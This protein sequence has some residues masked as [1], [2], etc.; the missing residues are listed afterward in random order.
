M[1]NLTKREL[2]A[3]GILTIVAVAASLLGSLSREIAPVVVSSTAPG[4]LSE[5]TL[6]LTAA[7]LN[8]LGTD[9]SSIANDRRIAMQALI[10][11][12]PQA[13]VDA[14]LSDQDLDRL[15][16]ALW[17]YL[18]VPATIEGQF[19]AGFR[20]YDDRGEEFFEIT[21][22]DTTYTVIPN[23]AALN[24]DV[25]GRVRLSGILIDDTLV[26]DPALP[27]FPPSGR[28]T[29]HS[30][31]S[32]EVLAGSSADTTPPTI[33]SITEVDQSDSSGI[34]YRISWTTNEAVTTQLTYGTNRKRLN[35]IISDNTLTTTHN[36]LL[37]NLPAGSWIY[38][39]ITATDGSGNTAVTGLLRF[40]TSGGTTSGGSTGGGGGG[41]TNNIPVAKDDS[42]T[43]AHTKSVSFNVLSNDT[44]KD[45]KDTLSLATINGAVRQNNLTL[46]SGAT[47]TTT[48]TG[49]I[50][51][52][53]NAA[54][55]IETDTFS[56]TAT[57]GKDP[58]NP[59]TVTITITG[60]TAQND[61]PIANNDSSTTN[62]DTAVTINVRANDTDPNG[63]ALTIT[64]VSNPTHGSAAIVSGQVRYQPSANHN[65]QDSFT[66]TISD[67]QLT[68]SAVVSV[69]VTPINDAPTAN[70][71]T[72]STNMNTTLNGTSVLLNDADVDGDTLIA[73]APGN[74][75]QGGSV[76]MNGNGIFTYTPA[77]NF[78]GTD[79]FTYTA[80]D[81][82][83]GSAT[84]NVSITVVDTSTSTV[85]Y[86]IEALVVGGWNRLNYPEPFGSGAQVTFAFAE[87][88]PSYYDAS[89]SVWNNFLPFSSE[90]RVV[91]RQ[92][93]K[94]IES[95]SGL[96]FSETS[97]AEAEIVFGI[98]NI[99]SS[100][101]AYWPVFNGVGNQASD[102]WLDDS[103]Y[104]FNLEP[105]STAYKTLIHELGHAIGL[106]HPVLP[107]EEDSR[108]Y[109]VIAGF[110]HPSM[111]TLEPATYQLFDIASIQYL[112]GAN[113][114]Y[115]SGNTTYSFDTYSN[116]IKTVWDGGGA[117][118]LDMST[119]T[120]G[121]T[122]DLRGGK[123]FSAVASVG[124][125]NVTT[126]FNSTIEHVIGSSHNDTLIGNDAPNV[127]SFR[128]GWGSDTVNN[129]TKGSDKLSF[130]GTGLSYNQLNISSSGGNTVIS[131]G[132]NSITVT[133]VT[134][135]S[136]SD[137]I[138]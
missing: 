32:G 59:A 87:A 35:S 31:G 85:P 6:A 61:A 122:I 102:V 53:P 43:T 116:Q 126:A 110:L 47:L 46:P 77:N 36:A 68:D 95:F 135:L 73:T 94:D 120:Y 67:G 84:G 86:Y 99:G 17:E 78:S 23:G 131:N 15:P 115:Q 75:T 101:L 51:Y 107:P 37:T 74:T 80:S 118:T 66:Y 12:D 57:D 111:G 49:D 50:T 136:Q 62:E 93:L 29:P 105:G 3:L 5:Q 112:Y 103:F 18:E 91:A 38:Y 108:Q 104:Q 16:E 119:A 7:A 98:A 129:F 20:D 45:R 124:T 52:T 137:F 25:N 97:V 55:T 40:Q 113:M 70:V 72:Y 60:F 48:D 44:D 28:I 14:A 79:S 4:T 11:T 39:E 100:G 19:A 106:T 41:K 27:V 9:V 88:T 42:V 58:S 96:T 22:G 81:G 26:V 132:G 134:G 54:S 89:A 138:F 125:N 121:V 82:K 83:G 114:T 1:E 133:G 65:G 13:I 24:P 10:G 34:H 92:V 109:S 76:S 69:T 33:G 63:D 117:D 30:D 56:Y 21:A 123:N 2:V 71:D 90:Q 128:S 127:F 64:A 8:G 130:T